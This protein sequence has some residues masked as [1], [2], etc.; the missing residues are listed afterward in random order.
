MRVASSAVR[1][2]V[3]PLEPRVQAI[4]SSVL[5][6]EISSVDGFPAITR[7]KDIV[8]AEGVRSGVSPFESHS[9]SVDL[10]C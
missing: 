5:V 10:P 2:R 6:E 1:V 9:C 8:V 7:I 3:L 4:T